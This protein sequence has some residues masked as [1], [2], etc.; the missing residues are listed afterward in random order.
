MTTNSS[1]A[2]F[3]FVAASGIIRSEKP[4]KGLDAVLA[5]NPNMMNR[6][7]GHMSDGTKVVVSQRPGRGGM[8]FTKLL[9][10]KVFSVAADALS[11]VFERGADGKPTKTIKV[12]NGV[13]L[14]SSS[15]F[16]T[17]STKDHPALSVVD[18][19][20]RVLPGGEQVLLVTTD[21]IANKQTLQLASDFDLDVLTDFLV[22]AL[23]D[24]HNLVAEFDE[25]INKKREREGRRAREDA[26][27]AN[28]PFEGPAFKELAVSRK[29]GNPLALLAWR[30]ADGQVSDAV[31]VREIEGLNDAE[32]PVTNYVTARE[33][34][35]AF[36]NTDAFAQLNHE[37]S[38]GRPV[39]MSFA[40]GHMM[41]CSV[42]FRKKVQNTM[43]EP[44]DKPLYGDA[45][46]I[47]GVTASWGRSI[48]VLMN[49]QHPNF[50][51]ADYEAH[52]YVAAPR[53]AEIGMKKKADGS[54][55]LPPQ[56]VSYD[57]RA[58]LV[59]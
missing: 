14:Y 13:P 46:Y 53:Q 22:A 26:E 27:E 52:H 21:A 11:P 19:Y 18:C 4:T 47:R 12:E 30:T 58:L 5:P 39:S 55:W 33:A 42:S 45:A 7:I 50:P 35:E 29:D 2:Q 48:V 51:R 37:L 10:G 34:V 8:D 17:L 15:G 36:Q 40:V 3:D 41:R 6:V 32:R 54:G 1:H 59:T 44:A 38:S 23:D 43:A 20:A 49:S 56:M 16:Y 9:G 31:I 57:V 25:E 24:S 28:E